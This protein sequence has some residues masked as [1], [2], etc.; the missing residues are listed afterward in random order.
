MLAYQ[1]APKDAGLL[2]PEPGQNCPRQ[3]NWGRRWLILAGIGVLSA[4]SAAG[5]GLKPVPMPPSTNYLLG[6]G[7]RVRV[8]V[9]GEE[10]LTGEFAVDASGNIAL[11][12]IGDIRAAGLSPDQLT[13]SIHAALMKSK[14]YQS[15]SVSVEVA[16][17]RPMFLLGEVSKP[18]QYPYQPGMS[19]LTAVAIAG[20]FTY[21]AVEDRFSI[22][23]S[24]DD[25]PIEGLGTRETLIQPG[26]VITVYERTF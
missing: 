2:R 18:G 22:V 21:R 24:T 8:I 19:V 9:F 16:D 14:L 17:Y 4:C 25:G 11:P 7:D 1:S 23:R 5:S 15:P 10:Q 26:D 20:G 3:T 6:P 12:L 13:E